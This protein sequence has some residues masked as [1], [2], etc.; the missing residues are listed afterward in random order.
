M[1]I[2]KFF[3]EKAKVSTSLDLKIGKIRAR[4]Q[5]VGEEI[6]D[7]KVVTPTSVVSVRGTGMDVLETDKGANVRSLQHKLEVRDNLGR[8]EIVRPDQDTN[9][10][11]GEVP[12]QVVVEMQDRAKVDTAAIGLTREEIIQRQDVDVPEVKPGEPG[13]SGSVS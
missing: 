13:K 6:S 7:F 3:R 8:P 10:R 2:D 9:V 12:T 4:V 11:P 5:R 1:K